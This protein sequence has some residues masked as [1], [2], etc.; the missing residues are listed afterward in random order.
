MESFGLYHQVLGIEFRT[1]APYEDIFLSISSSL[2]FEPPFAL[3]VTTF[4]LEEQALLFFSKINLLPITG[5]DYF[6]DGSL[7]LT[8]A[9]GNRFH[10][11]SEDDY[12]EPWQVGSAAHGWSIIGTT[13]GGMLFFKSVTAPSA[14]ATNEDPAPTG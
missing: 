6:P 10:I 14:L 12:G 5:L 1:D 7:A 11:Q 9:N 3:P 4:S 13:G 2:T 8:F